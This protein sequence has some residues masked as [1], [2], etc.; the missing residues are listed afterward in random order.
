MQAT[1]ESSM[2]Y[3]FWLN[4]VTNLDYNSHHRM[5]MLQMPRSSLS[6]PVVKFGLVLPPKIQ[7]QKS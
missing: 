1:S 2:L 5:L 4:S 3:Q 6:Y 7:T